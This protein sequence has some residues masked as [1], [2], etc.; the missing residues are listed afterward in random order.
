MYVRKVLTRLASAGILRSKRARHGGFRRARPLKDI[1]LLDVEE[2]VDGP[3]RGEVPTDFATAKDGLDGRLGKVCQGA[4]ELV[5]AR[6]GRVRLSAL[7][8]G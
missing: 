7:V 4:A 6:L 5:R 1:T 8:K 3:V 2:A